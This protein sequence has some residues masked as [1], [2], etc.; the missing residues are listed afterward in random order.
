MQI[1][2][3]NKLYIA[4]YVLYMCLN[5]FIIIFKSKEQHH[6]TI[7]ICIQYV[8]LYIVHTDNTILNTSNPN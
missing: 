2:E 7:C 5:V 4:H 3:S 8:Q 1:V 6:Y